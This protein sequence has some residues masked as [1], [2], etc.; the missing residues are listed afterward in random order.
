MESS[1]RQDA[2]RI[3]ILK[4]LFATC[5]CMQGLEVKVSYYLCRGYGLFNH[6]RSIERLLLS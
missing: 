6:L 2:H 1:V 4:L 5:F 3:T